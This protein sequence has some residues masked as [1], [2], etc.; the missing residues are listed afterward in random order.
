MFFRTV[1]HIMDVLT[2]KAISTQIR[3]MHRYTS[4]TDNV[5]PSLAPYGSYRRQ[6]TLDIPCPH[7]GNRD[8]IKYGTYKGDQRYLCTACK[9]KFRGRGYVAYK[10]YPSVVIDHARVLSCNM[11]TYQVVKQIKKDYGLAPSPST[12]WRWTTNHFGEEPSRTKT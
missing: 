12:I 7:C 4:F 1:I 3:H 11:S 6:H 8:A 9:R 5:Q 10:V 2:K